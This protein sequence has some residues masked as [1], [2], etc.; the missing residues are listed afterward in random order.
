MTLSSH[1]TD[2][3]L[4]LCDRILATCAKLKA[5]YAKERDA[6]EAQIAALN[7]DK[8]P[9]AISESDAAARDKIIVTQ[10]LDVVKRRCTT[11]M[12]DKDVKLIL[13][14]EGFNLAVI[15]RLWPQMLR[16]VDEMV[17]KKQGEVT[18]C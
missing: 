16:T 2:E 12:S 18:R 10:M 13:Y 4:A 6:V 1:Q 14:G 9:W 5:S 8:G 17:G 3:A 7:P 15:W 11:G